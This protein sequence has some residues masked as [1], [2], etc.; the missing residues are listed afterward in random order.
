[1]ALR[2]SP[3]WRALPVVLMDVQQAALDKALATIPA[4]WTG[5]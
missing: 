2:M 1:M 3:L 5:R 4:T